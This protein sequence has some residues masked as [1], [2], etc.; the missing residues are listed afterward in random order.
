M[1]AVIPALVRPTF[2]V[3]MEVIAA[4]PQKGPRA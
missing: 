1:L 2:L 4:V 3:E